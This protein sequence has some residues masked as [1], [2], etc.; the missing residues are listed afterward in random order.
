MRLRL[1]S[2]NG[3]RHF[4]GP[5][6]FRPAMTAAVYAICIEMRHNALLGARKDRNDPVAAPGARAARGAVE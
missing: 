1:A 3:H 4:A 5:A 6:A 2:V